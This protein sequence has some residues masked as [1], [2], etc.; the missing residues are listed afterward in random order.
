MK[1]SF[2]TVIAL[3]LAAVT[4]CSLSAVAFAENPGYT[5]TAD[6]TYQADE[7]QVFVY[8]VQVSAG[9]NLSGAERVRDYM[10]SKGFDGFI[11]EVD[12]GYRIMSGKFPHREDAWNY[13]DLIHKKTERG[14]AYVTDVRLPQ[15]AIDEFAENFRHDPLVANKVTFRGWENPSGPF[16]DMALNEE[17]TAPVFAVQYGAG[18]SF[19]GAERAR[20]M[21]IEKG[22]DAYVVRMPFFY[23]I[24]AGKFDNKDDATA[25]RDEIRV[26]TD[27]WDP[28]VREIQLPKA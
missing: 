16:I 20:D 21:L 17:E 13:C 28:Y 26:A 6:Q 10:L 4:L 27:H 22:F 19:K 12:G 8:T 9:C 14:T 5:Y 18:N 15:E 11:F 23:L 24:L 1:K 3:L 2:R 25:L 7:N